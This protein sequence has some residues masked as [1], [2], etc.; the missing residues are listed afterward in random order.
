[1]S[2]REAT[3]LTIA[4]YGDEWLTDAIRQMAV[5]ELE[6]NPYLNED[7][8]ANL[9]KTVVVCNAWL[10]APPLAQPVKRET[11]KDD[12]SEWLGVYPGMCINPDE[13]KGRSSCPRKLSCCE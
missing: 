5:K 13:C 9:R 8:K 1:M 12:W 4:R 11:P 10:D 7:E 3:I 2:A 6:T